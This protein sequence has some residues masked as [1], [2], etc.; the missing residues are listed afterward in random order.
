MAKIIS[1]IILHSLIFVLVAIKAYCLNGVF[2]HGVMGSV[3]IPLP[4]L[5]LPGYDIIAN[6]IIV[7][8]NYCALCVIVHGVI[9][10][11]KNH[12]KYDQCQKYARDA[13][14]R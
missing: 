6:V 1:T 13:A 12:G 9:V 4:I 3:L 10:K 14:G 11:S 2:V 5:I 8:V 7:M